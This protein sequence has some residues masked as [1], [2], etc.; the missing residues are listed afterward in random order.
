VTVPTGPALLDLLPDLARALTG[1][2]P[3]LLP[4]SGADPRA[5]EIARAL[6]AGE[7]L[8]PGEDGDPGSAATGTDPTALVVATSGSTGTPKGVLLSAGALAASAAATEARLGGPGSWLLALPANHIAGMQVLLRAVAAGTEPVLLDTAAPFTAARFLAAA[9]RVP[10]PRRYVSLVPT[11]L[12][13]VLADPDARSAAAELFD[14]ILVGGSATPATLLA[15][16][17]T[18]GLRVVTTYGMTETCGGCVYDGRPLDGVTARIAD[19]GEAAGALVLAG[20]MVA[21]GYRN[22]PG[23]P[24]FAIPGS[25]VTAD[26]GEVTAADGAA[27]S[28]TGSTVTVTVTGRLDDI[29]VTGGIKVS[30]AAVESALLAL[31]GIRSALVVGAPDAQWGQA[32]TALLVADPSWDVPAV[33]AAL[34]DLPASHRPRRVVPV[35]AVPMLASGKPDRVTARRLAAGG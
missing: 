16:A 25:F 27:D 22:R 5:P 28:T 19:T 4:L 8:A 23:D 31:P 7:P 32:V 30:P 29:I 18:A 3:P 12:H 17:R 15:E 1:D 11:Q 6:G 34:T 10:G 35:D 21:R 14:A 2:G 24:A 20:P 26:T 33:R 9:T 13:R